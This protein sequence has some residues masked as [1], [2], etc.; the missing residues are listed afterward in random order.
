MKLIDNRSFVLLGSVLSIPAL[1]L[2]VEVK[3]N[4]PHH[5]VTVINIIKGSLMIS[6]NVFCSE[7][8][9][10]VDKRNT[11]LLSNRYLTMTAG[12]L[13]AQQF[14]TLHKCLAY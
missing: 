11:G 2:K 12:S 8:A 4:N 7:K 5:S 14:F 3:A 9:V 6:C 1:W 10:G 13:I